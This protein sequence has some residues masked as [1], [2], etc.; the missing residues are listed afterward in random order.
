MLLS[1]WSFV[2]VLAA[3]K[4]QPFEPFKL[5]SLKHLMWKTVFLL[6]IMSVR[7]VSELH[8]LCYKAP[9]LAMLVTVVVFYPNV[10][11]L[12]RV[13]SQFHVTQPSDVPA[14]HEEQ[15]PEI[16]LLCVR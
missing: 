12:P 13:A 2:L 11:R 4:Q 1:G 16:C 8:V 5:A 14:R 15:E 10:D 7:R 9:Y 6:A 3:L